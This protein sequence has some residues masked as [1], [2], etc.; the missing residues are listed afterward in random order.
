MNQA[1]WATNVLGGGS[2]YVPHLGGTGLLVTLLKLL[3]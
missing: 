1:A 3:F 2:S